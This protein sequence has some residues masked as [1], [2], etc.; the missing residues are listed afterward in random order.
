MEASLR[1]ET[2]VT[3]YH[4][5][6]RSALEHLILQQDRCDSLATYTMKSHVCILPNSLPKIVPSRQLRNSQKHKQT[7]KQEQLT[8]QLLLLCSLPYRVPEHVTYES[9]HRRDIPWQLRFSLRT[10]KKWRSQVQVL[11]ERHKWLQHRAS[12]PQRRVFSYNSELGQTD[13]I[14]DTC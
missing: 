6:G 2:S 9:R 8:A 5:I 10:A 1:S 14:C 11:Q 4:S 12:N 3:I 13:L 7:N